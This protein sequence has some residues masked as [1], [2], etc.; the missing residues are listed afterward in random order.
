VKWT[1]SDTVGGALGDLVWRAL[2]GITTLDLAA[3]IRG[4][5]AHP[6]LAV[7]S[8][9]DDAL[10]ARLKAVVGE[11]AAAAER[12]VRARVDSIVAAAAAPAR[13]RATV[14][15]ADAQGRLADQ[16]ARLDQLRKDLDQRLRQLTGGLR[17]R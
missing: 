8:N 5:L 6:A 9:L 17:L 7:H 13:A 12:Q 14:A 1:R 2:S 3:E 16:R 4:T 11:Q 15:T 10:A